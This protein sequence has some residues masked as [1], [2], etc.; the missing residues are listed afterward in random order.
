MSSGFTPAMSAWKS[1]SC[2]VSQTSTRGVKYVPEPRAGSGLVRSAAFV[3][4]TC[5]VMTGDLLG[6]LVFDACLAG[7]N[8]DLLRLGDGR[9]GEV[10]LQHAVLQLRLDLVRVDRHGE[11]HGAVERPEVAL[12]A[13]ANG[14]GM[15]GR[16]A[17]TLQDQL[18]G[19]DHEDFQVIQL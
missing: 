13:V 6:I 18:V 4:V 19:A 7:G 16:L 12:L 9:L 10:D 11:G 14:L 17:V 2:S 8:V 1:N 5:S 15:L 3:L